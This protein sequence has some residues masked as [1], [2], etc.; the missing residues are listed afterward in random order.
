MISVVE[1][2]KDGFIFFANCIYRISTDTG[3]NS[4]QWVRSMKQRAAL[5]IRQEY[6]LLKSY[7][8]PGLPCEHR[9]ACRRNMDS[10][11]T[12]FWRS[13]SAFERAACRPAVA[14]HSN[15]CSSDPRWLELQGITASSSSQSLWWTRV[16]SKVKT[17]LQITSKKQD[18]LSSLR[19]WLARLQVHQKD[20]SAHFPVI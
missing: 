9:H 12:Q 13:P 10:W 17:N 5:C 14:G 8:A 7:A 2:E 1:T 18:K 6:F 15:A 20:S 4:V 11:L 3:E 16:S 19:E